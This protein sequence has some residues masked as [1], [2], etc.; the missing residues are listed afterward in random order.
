M[1][2]YLS[3]RLFLHYS[4]ENWSFLHYDDEYFGGK[5]HENNTPKKLKM[6]QK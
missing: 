5:H 4:N 3:I 1:Y 6:V 2:V